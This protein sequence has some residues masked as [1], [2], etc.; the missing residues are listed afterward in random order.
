[1]QRPAPRQP[2][3]AE[4][5]SPS[6][7]SLNRRRPRRDSM[8][9]NAARRNKRVACAGLFAMGTMILL[10][11]LPTVVHAGFLCQE[12]NTRWEFCGDVRGGDLVVGMLFRFGASQSDRTEDAVPTPIKPR[13]V[14]A[15]TYTP[16]STLL[17][18]ESGARVPSWEQGRGLNR[19]DR[20]FDLSAH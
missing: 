1:M 9:M 11:G 20:R 4:S 13:R 7:V 14:I 5:L 10:A 2:V 8:G 16:G 18:S 17:P 19:I 15:P 3:T 6:S 12:I